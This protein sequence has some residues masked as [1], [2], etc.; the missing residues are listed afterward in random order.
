[1]G[2]LLLSILGQPWFRLLFG[3]RLG[4]SGG[5]GLSGLLH[6]LIQSLHPISQARIT[7]SE[8]LHVEGVQTYTNSAVST[9][10]ISW[11]RLGRSLMM[12]LKVGSP[13]AQAVDV[14]LSL[15][16]QTTMFK[17]AMSPSWL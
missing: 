14:L 7:T 12:I 16:L 5:D 3:S 6:R 4:R 8:V 15:P 13:D 17:D 10:A 2:L 9:S 11:K 1:M